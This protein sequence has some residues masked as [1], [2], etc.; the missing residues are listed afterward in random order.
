MKHL[1]NEF[2]HDGEYLDEFIDFLKTVAWS[3]RSP[4]NTEMFFLWS[5]IRS[6]KPEVFIESGTFMGYSANFICEALGRNNNNAEFTTYGF[7]LGNCLPFARKRI[8]RYPFARVIE[9]DSRELLKAR[10][11]ETRSTAFFID[12]PK[13]KNMPPLFFSILARFSNVQFIAV[14]DSQKESG[15]RNRYY[16]EKFFGREYPI[17]YCDASFQDKF[18]RLDEPLIGKSELVDWKPYHWNGMKQASYGTETG[19]VLPVLGKV[20]TPVSRMLFR[21][22]RQLRFNVY[23]RLWLLYVDVRTR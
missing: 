18:S 3:D 1:R 23:H 13:G 7:N 15:S 8:E 4:L 5:M 2:F 10:P 11:R 16:L 14:H 20:G 12:G 19:Y 21:L 9:G 17:M 6:T 22:Y